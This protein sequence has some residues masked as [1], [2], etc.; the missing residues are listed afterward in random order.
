MGLNAPFFINTING[1]YGD[2]MQLDEAKQ[3]LEENN[4]EL[5]SKISKNEKEVEILNKLTNIRDKC[6]NLGIRRS[7]LILR[8]LEEVIEDLKLEK[9]EI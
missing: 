1:F 6:Y 7:D 4:Y 5:K 2:F 3:I 8:K 9:G